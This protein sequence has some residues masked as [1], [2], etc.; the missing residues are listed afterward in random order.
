MDGFY[1]KYYYLGILSLYK[2]FKNRLIFLQSNRWHG[3]K[4]QVQRLL[5]LHFVISSHFIH[6]RH[7][8]FYILNVNNTFNWQV[9]IPTYDIVHLLIIKCKKMNYNI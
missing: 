9:L 3:K 8:L 7:I 6:I 5:Y 1:V 4:L 2:D